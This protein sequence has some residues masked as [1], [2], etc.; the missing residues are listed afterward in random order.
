MRDTLE[1]M[2]LAATI[3]SWPGEQA[4]V[5]VLTPR[6]IADQ[7]GSSAPLKWA[8][9]TKIVSALTVL[10]AVADGVLSLDQPA[11]P[12]G[13]TLRH[14]L[15][16]AS[17]LAMDSDQVMAAPG[18]RRIYSNRGIEVAAQTLEERSGKAFADEMRERVLGPLVMA[19]CELV[20]SPAHGLVGGI[21]DLAKL[22]AE[23]LDSKQ[24]LP[25][26]VAAASAL[27]FPDLSG[28]LPGYG[29]QE[30]N[31]WGLG[32]EIRNGKQ[33]HW[34]APGNSPA[35]FGHFGQSGSFVWVDPEAQLACVSLSD[36]PFGDWAIEAWPE[37]SQQVLDTYGS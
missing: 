4:A 31:D 26:V 10:D 13:S 14:L 21:Y 9:V 25:G 20:G 7:A 2:D 19:E 6:G 32:C 18:A 37:L 12:E 23:L 34:T 27:A 22:A 17:G 29:R 36:K 15:A 28:V 16:H 3:K 1:A 5:V 8:S 30:H 33:P 35:T 24:L 11:G